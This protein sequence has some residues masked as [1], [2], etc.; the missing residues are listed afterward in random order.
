MKPG[1]STA[2]LIHTHTV[3]F[4]DGT[5]T[6]YTVQTWGEERPDGTW[7]GRLEFHPADRGLPVRTTGQETTQP[8]RQALVYW[9]SGLEPVYFD[10]AF[11]RAR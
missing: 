1:V 9:A 2:E 4:R 11:D 10:G 8:N 3:L 6:A 7:S 5:G